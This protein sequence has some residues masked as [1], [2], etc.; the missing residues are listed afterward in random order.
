MSETG[1]EEEL[2]WKE[3]SEL[4]WP[5]ESDWTELMLDD[6]CDCCPNEMR[7]LLWRHGWNKKTGDGVSVF[8][9]VVFLAAILGLTNE[10]ATFTVPVFGVLVLCVESDF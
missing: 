9:S 3:E 4:C 7:P 5:E 6:F 1:E 2:L 10:L 8:R